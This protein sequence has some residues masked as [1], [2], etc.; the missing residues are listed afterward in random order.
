MKTKNRGIL[1]TTIVVAAM[2]LMFKL[3]GFVKQAVVAYYFGTTF[4]TDIYNLAFTFVGT[5]TSAFVRAISI[6]MVSI[7]THTLLQKGKEAASKLICACLEFM[8]P[9]APV[10]L[11]F[12]YMFTPFIAKILAP[13]YSASES[14]L[15]QHYLQICF[16]FFIFSIFTMVG[17]ALMDSN[18]DFIVSRT[19]SF[20]TSVVTIACCVLLYST[21][22]VTSLVI[23]QYLSYILFI[24]VLF[25][26]SRLYVTYS[27]VRFRDVPELR[28]ILRAALP[29]F[30]GNSVFQLNKIVDG[31]ISSG[32]GSGNATAL[33][34]AIVLEDLVVNVIVNNAV[35]IL[36]VNFSNYAAEGNSQKLCDT[37]KAAVNS[38]I[39]IMTPIT[40][41]TCLCAKEIVSI[42]FL[43]GKFD[44][45]SLI[46]TSAALIG[47]AI[48]FISAGVRDL[49]SRA[50]YAFKDTKGPMITGFF[51]VIAN[52][53]FSY[54][55]SRYI[56][57]MGV[58]IATSI[59]LTVNFVIN[60]F[61][62]KKYLDDYSLAA[63][64]P[65][66]LKQIPGGIVLVM[67][68]L[69][70]KHIFTSNILI[71]GFSAAIGLLIYAAILCFMKIDEVNIIKSRLLT[72]LHK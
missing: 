71:F 37:M 66:L 24:G 38:M 3:L 50:L 52:I 9:I 48:G 70:I 45:N 61:M 7:Y 68:V 8:L 23:A 36:Y 63:F 67:I 39:C 41:I 56:G 25:F 32:L 28:V 6:S 51:A 26:R 17:T 12:A 40:I 44:E 21:Q 59:F 55:L 47:Y 42:V 10:I 16:P 43:R 13:S 54:V 58:T 49:A 60:S 14:L 46:M 29:V 19:E 31:S 22:A 15:L 18:K 1:T 20:F 4:E 27:F 5:L 30:I 62:L 34:Y 53:F 72:K 33:S 64:V 57:I 11:L 65:V 2:T 69:G 35:D